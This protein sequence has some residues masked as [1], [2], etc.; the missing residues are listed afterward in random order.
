MSSSEKRQFSITSILLLTFVTALLIAIPRHAAGSVLHPTI[1]LWFVTLHQ[2]A[3]AA[4]VSTIIWILLGRRMM[5]GFF[6]LLVTLALWGPNL[7][8]TI[9]YSTTGKNSNSLKVA[10]AIGVSPFL[11]KFYSTTYDLIGYDFRSKYA[12]P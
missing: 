5:V 10:N 9:E 7:A 3:I 8:A 1:I 4:A 6:L 2:I 11:N 12:R